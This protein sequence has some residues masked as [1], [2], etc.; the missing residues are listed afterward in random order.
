MTVTEDV[1]DVA[2]PGPRVEQPPS[3]AQRRVVLV[4]VAAQVLGGVGVAAGVAVGALL[5]AALAS[6]ALS[7]VASSATVI[8][9]ALIAIP[10]S[11]V[12]QVNGRRPGLVLAYIVG[13]G[14]ALVIVAGAWANSFPIALL[15]MIAVGGGT[16]ATLQSR[17]AATDLATTSGRGQALSIVVWATTV[18][19]V[20]GPNLVAPM[21]SVASKGGIPSLAGPFLLSAVAFGL[22]A[23]TISFLLRPDPLL[24]A[25]TA[26]LGET[27]GKAATASEPG[28]I[29]EAPM[30]IRATPPA[31]LGLA[32]VVLGHAVMVAVM[33]MTPV[34]L[35]HGGASLEVVG[36]VISVHIAGM[37]AASPLVGFMADRYGRHAVII[38]GGLLLLAS[39]V[40][41]GTAGSHAT[42]QIGIG[43]TVL[44]LG[45]SC[46]LIA[47]STLLTETIPVDARPS[48]QGAA[49][50]VMGFGGA[51]TGLLAGVVVGVGSYALL[52]IMTA[53][54][55]VPLVVVTASR[56]S[57]LLST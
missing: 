47:G 8:G 43:L 26:R 24:T 42:T 40:I 51:T 12:M 35:Q 5:M 49:D 14:G 13:L 23:L 29:R 17:Y 32:A 6:D 44:G 54:M 10:V 18:G 2:T 48:A 30:L 41:A 11:G 4:L 15:G 39:F 55:I 57:R 28:S 50:L 33:S 37:Y 21:G 52:T 19:S 7:G 56:Q 45:W 53:A 31:L 34:H 20:V 1:A 36:I 9:A 22:A 38:V 25:R 27:G 16:T 46:A 3:E